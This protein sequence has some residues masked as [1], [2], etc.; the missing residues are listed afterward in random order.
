M[1]A[2]DLFLAEQSFGFMAVFARVGAMV[3]LFPAIGD[4]NVPARFRLT[5]AL[6]LSGVL[7]PAILPM[8]PKLPDQPLALAALMGGEILTGLTI[9]LTTRLV[10]SALQVAG[11]TIAMQ[12]GLGFVQAVD[13]TFGAQG[14]L[15]GTFLSLTAVTFIFAT[16]LHALLFGAILA[17]YD[18][19]APGQ[20]PP[21]D[22]AAK[23]AVDTTAAS[24]ALGVQIS[25]PFLVFGL[26]FNAAAGIVNKLM[27]QIQVFFIL[28]PL[29]IL[30]GLGL[31]MVT[32]SASIIW[33]TEH[34]ADH[35]KMFIGAG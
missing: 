13:P 25:A 11:S 4:Q 20:L 10:M 2:L 17:S 26:V 21:I 8:M 34:F 19:F 27:P 22:D 5:F 32:L 23:F 30:L 3:M 31:F 6:A 29:S 16:G 28:M 1:P 33:F 15:L 12:T 35:L 9:G 24:F 14:A 18:H 7:A